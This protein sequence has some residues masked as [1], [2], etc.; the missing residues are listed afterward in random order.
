[1]NLGQAKISKLIHELVEGGRSGAAIGYSPVYGLDSTP[2]NY[3]GYVKC[4]GF[5]E[6]LL[7]GY[8]F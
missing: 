5:K 8:L 2:K 1:M 7:P 4:R 3:A 6:P